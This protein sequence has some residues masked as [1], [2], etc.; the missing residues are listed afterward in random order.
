MMRTE[1]IAPG[2]V[3]PMLAAGLTLLHYPA[4][5]ACD[6]SVTLSNTILTLGDGIVPEATR[7]FRATV[8]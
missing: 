8:D 6:A 2:L 1:P 3:G 4:F 7:V 5:A